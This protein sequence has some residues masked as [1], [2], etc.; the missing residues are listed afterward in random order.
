M[1]KENLELL[2]TVLLKLDGVTDGEIL[3]K[4]NLYKYLSKAKKIIELFFT[5]E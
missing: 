3:L 1:K 5:K 4:Y 2:Q